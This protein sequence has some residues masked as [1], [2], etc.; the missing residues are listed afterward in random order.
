MQRKKVVR[1]SRGF[2]LLEVTMVALIFILL[3][4]IAVP[5]VV[6]AQ[7]TTRKRACL[8]ML[9][10]IE[11]AKQE[12]LM[13]N[14]TS[15]SVIV[16]ISTL[17]RRGYLQGSFSCPSGGTYIGNTAKETIYCSVHGHLNE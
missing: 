3:A 9:E 7:E 11:S 10:K 5:N 15:D 1:R 14:P 17:K 2:T 16:N 6:Q 4:A 12:F 13:A 8:A